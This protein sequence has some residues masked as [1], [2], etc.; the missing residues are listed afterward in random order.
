M[1]RKPLLFLCILCI[2]CCTDRGNATSRRIRS[3]SGEPEQVLNDD[4]LLKNKE[5]V[6][7]IVNV[8]IENSASM[9]GYVQGTADFK[10]TVYS[11]LQYIK[12]Q[13]VCD[14]LNL[15]YLNS[16]IFPQGTVTDDNLE[17]L[18]YFVERLDPN[19]FRLKGT[20]PGENSRGTSD[21]DDLLRSIISTTD[22]NVISILITDGIFSPGKG[23][24]ANEYVAAQK[25]GLMGTFSTLMNKI[26]NAAVILYKMESQF[27]GIYYDKT[28]T[29]IPYRGLRPYYIWVVGSTENLT[30]LLNKVPKNKFNTE[31]EEIFMISEVTNQT[32]YIVDDNY[33][34]HKKNKGNKYVVEGLT[35]DKS[36]KVR[37]AVKVD[38]SGVLVD[39]SYL[40]NPDNYFYNLNNYSLEIQKLDNNPKYTHKL[41][42]AS[43]DGKPHPGVM[44]IKLKMEEPKWAESSNDNYGGSPLEG[45]T[46]GLKY[47]IDGLYEA[48]TKD[49]KDVQK[50]YNEIIIK[51]Q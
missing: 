40:L 31:P 9:D 48:F 46:Y 49:M 20:V 18:K 1:I 10:T 42:F 29:K 27:E 16:R 45:K 30:E 2:I 47:Q 28:D 26:K 32:R 14:S 38:L 6:K 35:K 21:I 17:V 15:F 24:D 34:V 50:Y 44:S 7:P 36:G 23:R 25:I 22:E 4:T 33:G 12:I 5:R 13:N 3:N 19:S 11:F 37:F 41:K 8:Y 43:K 39:D 51:I